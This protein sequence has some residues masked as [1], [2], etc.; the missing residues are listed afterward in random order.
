MDGRRQE[1]REEVR[2]MEGEKERRHEDGGREIRRNSQNS[3]F[4]P[5]GRQGCEMHCCT[6][7]KE[8]ITMLKSKCIIIYFLTP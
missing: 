2:R 7:L 4:D 1:R 3:Q 5:G 6:D 8:N